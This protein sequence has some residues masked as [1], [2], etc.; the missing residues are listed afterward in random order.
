MIIFIMSALL[1]FALGGGVA[2]ARRAMGRIWSSI[3][4]GATVAGL[5]ACVAMSENGSGVGPAAFGLAWLA[6]LL[7]AAKALDVRMPAQP[8]LVSGA[9]ESPI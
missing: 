3:F 7:T 1:G 6:G 8:A 2:F 5:V 9:S 4:G